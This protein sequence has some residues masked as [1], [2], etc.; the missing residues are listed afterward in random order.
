VTIALDSTVLIT[1]ASQG[2]GRALSVYFAPRCRQVIGLARN[3]E[4]LQETGKLVAASVGVFEVHRCDLSVVDDLERLVERLHETKIPVDIVINNAA[5]V[6]SQP[7]ADTSLT[8]IDSI[9][10]TNVTGPLQLAR[11]LIPGMLERGGGAIVNISSLAGYKPNPTQTVYSVSKSAVNGM[12]DALRA[13]FSGRG[14]H[15]LNVPL[16]SVA[17]EGPA[18]A[19]EIPMKALAEA[20]VRALERR[21]NELFFSRVTKWLMRLYKAYPPL[22]NLR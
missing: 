15:V 16:A 20:L 1:G 6:T 5:D 14:I 2:I 8:E 9:I 13:E 4:G 10:R 12:S 7:L 18:S 19:G 21:Q 17:I 22:M 3:A 11:L